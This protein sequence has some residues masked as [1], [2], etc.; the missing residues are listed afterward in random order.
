MVSWPRN[1]RCSAPLR[2]TAP[3][4]AL[5]VLIGGTPVCGQESSFIGSQSCSSTSCHGHTEPRY[6][7]GTLRLQESGLYAQHDPHARAART[8]QSAAFQAILNRLSPS[9]D[10]T[11]DAKLYAKCAQCHD[12][13]G[14]TI[15][16]QVG[17][18]L[19]PPTSG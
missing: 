1:H 7:A 13:E 2:W 3:L 19:T 6:A 14:L 11:A 12:P 18:R 4:C 10:G 5:A 17:E 8:L 16:K 15:A 9:E